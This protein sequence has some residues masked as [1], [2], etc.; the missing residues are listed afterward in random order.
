MHLKVHNMI[1]CVSS[2][3]V[4]TCH[5]GMASYYRVVLEKNYFCWTTTNIGTLF[6]RR[7][8]I[9]SCEKHDFNEHLWSTVVVKRVGLRKVIF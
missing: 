7:V 1:F 4:S 6:E 3:P 5:K 9:I 8:A 2:I